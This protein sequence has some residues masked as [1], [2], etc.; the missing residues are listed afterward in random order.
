MKLVVIKP[1][2]E[3]DVMFYMIFINLR[4]FQIE[5]YM[6]TYV[7]KAFLKHRKY[8]RSKPEVGTCFF[9]L[10]ELDLM[11]E[12]TSIV[13]FLSLWMAGITILSNF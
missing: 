8:F 1:E 2:I 6:S 11:R 4:W 13:H 12:A 10:I 9:K 3:G 7:F 5:K